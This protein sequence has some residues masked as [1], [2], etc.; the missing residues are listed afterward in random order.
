VIIL[1]TLFG[2]A[3]SAE[4]VQNYLYSNAKKLAQDIDLEA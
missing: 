4:R 3:D 2:V 1:E